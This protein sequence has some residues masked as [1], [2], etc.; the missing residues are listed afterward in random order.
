MWLMFSGAYIFMGIAVAIV[1]TPDKNTLYEI[2][3]EYKNISDRKIFIHQVIF[4][5][6]ITLLWP[7]TL[8]ILKKSA[9]KKE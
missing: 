4:F 3:K 7:Y 8:F 9:A 5:T 6:V 1:A 2:N